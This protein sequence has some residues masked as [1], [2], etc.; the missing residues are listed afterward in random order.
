MRVFLGFTYIY[1][2][3]NLHH[4]SKCLSKIT[5]LL[6]FLE[7]CD[8]KICCNSSKFLFWRQSL[9]GCFHNRGYQFMKVRQ[10]CLHHKRDLKAT[11]WICKNKVNAWRIVRLVSSLIRLLKSYALQ[12]SFIWGSFTPT[13]KSSMMILFSH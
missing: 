4:R 9:K 13:L 3:Q 10:T 1:L 5:L 12:K 2:R 6:R 11:R 7:I 8:Y